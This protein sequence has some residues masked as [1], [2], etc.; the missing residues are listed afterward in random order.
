MSLTFAEARIDRRGLP[1]PYD[2]L[3]GVEATLR[4]TMADGQVVYE[5]Q[6]FPI[7]ELAVAL[8]DWLC[9]GFA[10]GS[11][12]SFD[13]V[14]SDDTGLLWCRACGSGW[15]IGALEQ[16]FPDLTMYSQ[17]EVKALFSRFIATVDEWL[18]AEIGGSLSSARP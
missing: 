15:R 6:F 5:E 10:V 3:L 14:E 17:A 11:D 16:D 1:R 4:L 2:V 7:V 8:Q 12:F 13:S 18:K 9:D